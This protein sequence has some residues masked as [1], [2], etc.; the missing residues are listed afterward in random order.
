MSCQPHRVTSGQSD[1]GHKQMHISK[2]FSYVYKSFVKSVHKTNHFANLK[3]KIHAQTSDTNFRR[4]RPFVITPVKRAHKA[5]TCWYHWSFRL[6]H[7]YQIKERENIDREPVSFA[8]E[9]THAGWPFFSPWA[10]LGTCLC[11]K[12]RREDLEEMKLNG[13][14]SC[15]VTRKREE[16]NSCRWA[17]YAWLY[18]DLQDLEVEP[19]MARSRFSTKGT[20]TSVS[21]VS[22]CRSR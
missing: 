5:R 15:P 4:V 17:K 12:K 8:W 9:H 10:H 22:H 14:G 13:P 20:L 16:K 21:A 2:L 7:R 19:L 1:S 11:Q 6:I 3:Q 18:S